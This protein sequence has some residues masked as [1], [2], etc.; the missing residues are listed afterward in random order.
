[1]KIIL[2]NCN[3]SI[4]NLNTEIYTAL[5]NY[6]WSYNKEYIESIMQWDNRFQRRKSKMIEEVKDMIRNFEEFQ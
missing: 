1:M 3:I 5:T 4:P 2:K 6:R